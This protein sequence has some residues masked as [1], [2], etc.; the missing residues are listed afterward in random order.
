[1]IP[2]HGKSFS[3]LLCHYALLV[4]VVVFF[5]LS[6]IFYHCFG[7]IAAFLVSVARDRLRV[8]LELRNSSA[9]VY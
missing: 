8:E 6:M 3:L 4:Y 7:Q 1:M 9:L 2:E 5:S